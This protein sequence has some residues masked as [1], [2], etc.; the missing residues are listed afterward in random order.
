MHAE[1]RDM[2]A[3]HKWHLNLNIFIHLKLWVDV[4]RQRIFH[5]NMRLRMYSIIQ[6]SAAMQ[7][8]VQCIS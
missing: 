4:A 1:V 6:I 3:L 7:V 8:H 5:M 2:R